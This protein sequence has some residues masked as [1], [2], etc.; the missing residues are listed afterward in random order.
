MPPESVSADRL[1]QAA[2][3]AAWYMR[4]GENSEELQIVIS[5]LANKIEKFENALLDKTAI[6]RI[7]ELERA[8]KAIPDGALTLHVA[9]QR[10]GVP[11]KILYQRVYRAGV[12]PVFHAFYLGFYDYKTLEKLISEHPLRQRKNNK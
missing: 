12:K 11:T 1:Q 4:H 7:P 9:A 6:K 3:W 2:S 5:Y 8:I 10:L